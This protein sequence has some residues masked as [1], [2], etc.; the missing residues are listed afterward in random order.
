MWYNIRELSI[1]TT[2]EGSKQ[3]HENV[4]EALNMF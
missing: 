1:V 2:T 3:F 4:R